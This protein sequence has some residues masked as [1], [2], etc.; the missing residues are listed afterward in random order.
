MK[1]KRY[2]VVVG[3][4]LGVVLVMG[5]LFFFSPEPMKID[6]Y[7]L[8]TKVIDGDTIIIEGGDS[9]RL[10]GIDAD[11]RGY[12]CYLD[13]KERLESVVLGREVLLEEDG[14]DKDQYDRYLRYVMLDGE[15][16]SILLAEE[17]LVV[18]RFFNDNLRYSEDIVAG[19]KRAIDQKIGCKWEVTE[20]DIADINL[21]WEE[22]SETEVVDACSAEEHLGLEV[23]VE[24]VVADSHFDSDSGTTFLNFG[25]AYPNHCFT[26]VVFDD[27]RELFIGDIEEYYLNKAV[28]VR[29]KIEEYRGSVEIILDNP[30]NIEVGL[31][32]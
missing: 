32:R 5:L 17:G 11:E 24:G 28:R 16:L 3:V 23:I 9:V 6:Q 18:A 12:P 27:S 2:I 13:A 22:L 30:N 21:I 8:V 26:V 10:L 1:S 20:K 14:E 31:R 7:I 25:S 15:N 19:E 4:V 29:G